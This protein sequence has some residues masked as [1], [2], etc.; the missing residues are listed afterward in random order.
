M[1]RNIVTVQHIILTLLLIMYTASMSLHIAANTEAPPIYINADSG[2]ASKGFPGSGT[3]EDP[4]RIENLR[5]KTDASNRNGIEIRNTG[6]I[7]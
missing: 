6:P 4:Y 3:K 7:S 5:I 1:R 2:F